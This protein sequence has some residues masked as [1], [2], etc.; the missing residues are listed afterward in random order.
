MHRLL[1]LWITVTALA[2][3][4]CTSDV[5]SGGPRSIEGCD[6]AMQAAFDAWADAGFSGSVAISVGGEP[7]C[8]A[9]YG[10]ADRASGAPNEVRTVFSIGSVTKAFTAAAVLD[11]VDKNVVQL[12]VPVGQLLPELTGPAAA[13]T[14]RQLL[15]HTSGLTG[16]HGSDYVPLDRAAAIEAMGSL[17]LAFAPGTAFLYSNAGYTLLALIIEKVSGL[18]YREYVTSRLLKVP[19]APIA[20][21]FWNGEP[22]APQPRVVGY[23]E[24]GSAGDGTDFGGPHWAVEGNGGIAMTMGELARWSDALFGGRVLTAAATATLTTLRFDR[25]DGVAEIPGWVAFDRARYGEP[26]YASA[27]GGGTGL[28]VVVAVLPESGRV[29]AFGSNTADVSAEELLDAVGPALVTGAPMPLPQAG[30]DVDPAA[31]A[32]L[33]GTYRLDSGGT[34]TVSA[35]QDRLAIAARGADAVETL[36][37]LPEGFS[38][39]EVAEHEA[40]VRSMLVAPETAAG[41]DERGS[42]E[43]SAGPID[44]VTLAGTVVRDNELRTYVEITSATTSHLFWYALDKAGG[45][46]AA[47]VD[48]DPPSLL[49]RPDGAGYRPDDPTGRGPD[50]TVR[51]DNADTMTVDGPAGARSAA[52]VR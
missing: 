52:R 4:A 20:A 39:D 40:A 36:F 38:R 41:R 21:G 49:L 43:R 35:A 51:F 10:I 26:A 3:G 12:D 22:A 44:R 18:S 5:S 19:G 48:A 9:A 24:D 42:I 2:V 6:P 1:A 17:E 28:N 27:G 46:A 13:V 25:G 31:V 11:L 47:E 7:V 29:I 15:L 30:N 16:S 14:V 34:F 23:R 50:L 8:R 37:P 33:T 32:A 45:I